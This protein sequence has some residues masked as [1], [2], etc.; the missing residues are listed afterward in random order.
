MQ[1]NIVKQ[2]VIDVMR[3]IEK[4]V[5][6]HGSGVVDYAVWYR[7]R[8]TEIRDYSDAI[9]HVACN[10]IVRIKFM[11]PSVTWALVQFKHIDDPH[12]NLIVRDIVTE[13]AAD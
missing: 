12:S 4:I 5:S 11:A 2:A 8:P 13:K 9:T 7:E 1:V 6:I 3:T 10:K